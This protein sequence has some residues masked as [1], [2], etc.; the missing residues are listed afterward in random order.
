MSIAVVSATNDFFFA[1]FHVAEQFRRWPAYGCAD[2]V[3]T[4]R[5]GWAHV[6]CSD[7]LLGFV[8]NQRL[9]RPVLLS[10]ALGM[11]QQDCAIATRRLQHILPE[12]CELSAERYAIV[13]GLCM[14]LQERFKTRRAFIRAVRAG[15]WGDAIDALG[16]WWNP[17]RR[18]AY[19][20][21]V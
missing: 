12:Y 2:Y 8:E 3:T 6:L 11:F 10:E 9:L 5:I 14:T 1:R 20:S 18:L 17:S 19:L 21:R 16:D 13:L 7:E 4:W 15:Q